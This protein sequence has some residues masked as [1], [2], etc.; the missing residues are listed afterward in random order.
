MPTI[1][2]EGEEI[3]KAVK[4]ISEMRRE[5]AGTSIDKL[6]EAACIKFDLSPKEAEYLSRFCKEKKASI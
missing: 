6:I 4:W 5:E 1:Q 2:P 3:R